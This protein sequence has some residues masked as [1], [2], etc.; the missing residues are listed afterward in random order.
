MKLQHSLFTEV[1][2]YNCLLQINILSYT[3]NYYYTINMLK[4][5]K[6]FIKIRPYL[7]KNAIVIKTYLINFS[8]IPQLSFT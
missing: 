6:Y 7:F 2:Y 1:H 5:I 4:I 3:L 8:L